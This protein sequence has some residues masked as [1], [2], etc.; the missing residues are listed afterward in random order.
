MNKKTIIS[1]T[2]IFIFVI[3]FVVLFKSIFGSDN[4]LIGVTTITAMLMFLSRDLT[5]SPIKNTLKLIGT[6]LL[7]GVGTSLIVTN[8]WLGIILNFIVVFIIAYSYCYNLRNP[9]YVPF[10]L[11]YEFLVSKPVP[12]DELGIRFLALI[13]GAI[14]IMLPQFIVNRNRLTKSGNKILSGVCENILGKIHN[15]QQ[16]KDIN[17]DNTNDVNLRL[18]QFREMVYD[19]RDSEYYL[20][21]EAKV[22]LSISVALE[23]INSILCK[24]NKTNIDSLTLETLTNLIKETN[25]ILN[26]NSKNKKYEKISY[27]LKD[28]IDYFDKEDISDLYNLQLLDSMIVLSKSINSLKELDTKEYNL[29]KKVEDIPDLFSKESIRSEFIG[30]KSLKFCYAMRLAITT[31]IGFFIMYY[32]KI[33]E[34]RWIMF[35]VISVT[36]PIYETS[37]DKIKDRVFATLIGSIIVFILFS[38]VK[39]ETARLLLVMLTGYL[40]GYVQQYRYNMIFV[41]VSAIGAAAV[42]GNINAITL[43]RIIFV[44]IGTIIAVLANRYL[45][46]YK[47]EDSNKELKTMYNEAIKG[48]FDEIKNLAEGLKR[49]QVIKNLFVNLTLIESKLRMNAQ[50]SSNQYYKQIIRERRSLANNV[51]ELYM[52]MLSEN[53]NIEHK[54]VIIE[55]AVNL[56]E[57]NMKPNKENFLY[58]ENKIKKSKEI[59]IRIILSNMLTILTELDKIEKLSI[60]AKL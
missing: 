56:V 58:L 29:V 26:S 42:A 40:Q 49:P 23:G 52:W 44:L 38:I 33:S 3:V 57:Y 14:I 51:Y 11:Q 20:T 59:E 27:N 2:A 19:K 12:A 32:F 34:A 36:T 54:K 41:T 6:N 10:L 22:K 55:D 25:N 5:V 9:L 30:K 31:G 39:N 7:I 4:T 18:D 50:V 46:P 53:I 13:V 60:K 16:S 45:F 8:V 17:K 24:C 35:T 28:L 15:I 37:K 48:M 47:L 1:K 21:E 43:D